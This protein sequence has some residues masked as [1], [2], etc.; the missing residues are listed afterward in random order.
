MA[1]YIDREVAFDAITDL[2]GKAPTRSAYEAVW[3]SARVLKKTPTAD[4]AP[5]VH[6][7]WIGGKYDPGT[8]DYMEQCSHCGVFSREYW[9]PYCSECGAKMDGGADRAAD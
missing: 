9:K 4:V 5:V 6:G 7:R 1:E 3:K 8:G 2:A